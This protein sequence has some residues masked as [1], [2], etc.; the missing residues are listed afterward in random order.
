VQQVQLWRCAA[1][2]ASAAV[3][4][5]SK[6]SCEAVEVCSKCSCGGVQQVRWDVLVGA[7]WLQRCSK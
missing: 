7:T 1:S 6:C 5:C 4:V 2:A 3:E